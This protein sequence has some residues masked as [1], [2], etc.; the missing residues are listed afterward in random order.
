MK[1]FP[2][3]LM[4]MCLMIACVGVFVAY[5]ATR[6]ALSKKQQGDDYGMV[7]YAGSA[8]DWY[9][10]AAAFDAACIGKTAGEVAGLM[11]SDSKGNAD[12]QAAGC[13]VVVSEFVK[14]ASKIG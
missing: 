11:G 8:K 13:T 10:Q 14:A 7:E 5:D 9:D 12:L 6:E 1:K 4:A 2:A 3:I